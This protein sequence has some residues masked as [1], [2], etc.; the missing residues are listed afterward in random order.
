[1]R[2]RKIIACLLSVLL[3]AVL[4]ACT[5]DPPDA[6]TDEPGDSASGAIPG[7]P[8]DTPEAEAD[9]L[10]YIALGDS[11]PAGYGVRSLDEMHT[12]IFYEILE[13]EQYANEYINMAVN[14]LT[15]SALLSLLSSS[16]ES[17]LL[18]FMNA[19][20][21]TLNIGGNNFLLTFSKYIPDAD[22][23]N[24]IITEAMDFVCE[25][26][27]LLHDIISF[28][29]ESQ[30]TITEVS[31]IASEIME[32][33]DSPSFSDIFRLSGIIQR[34]SA[35]L[36]DTIEVLDAVS[37]FEKAVVDILDRAAELELLSAISLMLGTFPPELEAEL[38]RELRGF[39]DDFAE[40]ISWLEDHA[41][42]ALIIVNTV[43]NPIPAQLFGMPLNLSNR[44]NTLIQS[45]NETI[46]N[47]SSGG[48]YVVSDIYSILSNQLDFMNVS[49]DIIHPNSIGHSLIAQLNYVDFLHH[50]ESA[51]E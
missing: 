25:A 33:T 47:E 28:V 9:P 40:I 37:G 24:R 10:I 20:V 14:G 5:D 50:M 32:I 7:V 51:M 13:N 22:E 4:A 46:Y 19:S 23:M 6:S 2:A 3:I 11:V 49:F 31:D 17:D 45:M 8:T 21:I 38:E 42:N 43:Y 39:S 27:A 35:V 12:H 1:M 15:T 41:P 26:E 18:N 34:A 48:R 44:A 29:E 16:D 30:D 36:G